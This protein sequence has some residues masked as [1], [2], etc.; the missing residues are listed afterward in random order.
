VDSRPQ[1]RH[2]RK[3]SPTRLSPSS[4]QTFVSG[5][6]PDLIG[7]PRRYHLFLRFF[8]SHLALHSA[9][10]ANCPSCFQSFTTI[11]FCNYFVLITI[12]IAPGVRTPLTLSRSDSCKFAPLFSITSRM[13]LSQPLSLQAFALLPGGSIPSHQKLFRK[14]TRRVPNVDGRSAARASPKNIEGATALRPLRPLSIAPLSL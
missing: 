5:V 14:M 9:F 1:P 13:L 11:K 12:R 2:A 4:L 7:V 6:H 3:V 10:T 8:A